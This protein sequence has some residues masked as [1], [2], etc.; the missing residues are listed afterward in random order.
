MYTTLTM[1]C[2]LFSSSNDAVPTAVALK[3]AFPD[4]FEYVQSHEA[5]S[6]YSRWVMEFLQLKA[7]CRDAVV[8]HTVNRDR[9][10]INE[11]FEALKILVGR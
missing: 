9:T 7:M 3:R 11:A 8:Y 6:A 2:Q 10:K 1:A 4:I 5:A